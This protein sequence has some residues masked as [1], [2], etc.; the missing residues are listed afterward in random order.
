MTDE[1]KYMIANTKVET[2]ANLM[3]W[4]KYKNI[5]ME[6][7]LLTFF[8]DKKGLVKIS[9]RIYCIKNEI[10]ELRK[11]LNCDSPARFMTT[12][13]GYS[14]C[15]SQKCSH[16][17]NAIKIQHTLMQRYGISH[18]LQNPEFLQKSKDTCM[19]NHMVDNIFKN[20]SY[21]RLKTFEKYGYENIFQNTTYIKQKFREKYGVDNPSQLPDAVEKS[22]KTCLER[23]GTEYSFQS[24]NN[25]N[26]TIETNIKKYGFPVA[27]QSQ[28]IKDKVKATCLTIYG[29]DNAMKDP[30]IREKIY[31]TNIERYGVP[32]LLQSDKH[33]VIM[34]DTMESRYGKRFSMQI[35]HIREKAIQTS[36]KNFGCEHPMQNHDFYSSM[37][38]YKSKEYILPSGRKIKLQGYE[39]QALDILLKM[40]DESDIKVSRIEM[41]KIWYFKNETMHKYYPDFYIPRDN[42]IIEV[43]SEWTMQLDFYI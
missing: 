37:N 33:K 29:V 28:H 34:G 36:I 4:E 17:A 6:I 39:P 9:E 26:K 8:L 14:D 11:C 41:P 24:E 19:N 20:K 31:N 38:I 1:L 5:K 30:Q 3:R 21:I 7:H 23:Y 22:K 35:P 12:G 32:F 42:L 15:C 13:I 16:K 27:M 18:A 25:K 2:I 10:N 43:K 40:Y